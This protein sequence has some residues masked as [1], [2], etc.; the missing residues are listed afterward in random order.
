MSRGERLKKY[1]RGH[2]EGVSRVANMDVE[3]MPP[4]GDCF[5]C[6]V[7]RGLQSAAAFVPALE[8]M[9]MDSSVASLRYLVAQAANQTLLET[10]QM[11]LESEIEGKASNQ[12]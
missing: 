9:D 1:L 2:V 7:E 3:C 12:G 11:Y 6:A 5:Y 8:G 4:T 10:Y